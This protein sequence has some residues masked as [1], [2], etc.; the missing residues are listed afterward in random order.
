MEEAVDSLNPV[1][2][3]GKTLQLQILTPGKC[4]SA[5][6]SAKLYLQRLGSALSR[7]VMSSMSRRENALFANH[8][9]LAGR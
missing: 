9:F 4:F 7:K 2:C 3:L 6:Q 5:W 8:I 1:Y